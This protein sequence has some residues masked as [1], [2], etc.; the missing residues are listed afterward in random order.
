[1][2]EVFTED[3]P[4]GTVLIAKD[5]KILYRKAFGKANLELGVDMTPEHVFR[6]GS[7]TKQFT[8]SAILKLRDEGK[9]E[10]D[11]DITKYLEDYP[12]HGHDITIK[13]LLTHTSRIK[14]YTGMEEWTAETRKKDFTPQELIE[15]FKYQPMDFKPGEEYRYNNSAYFILGYII[16]VVSG[17]SYEAYIDESFFKPIGMNDSYYGSTSRIIKNRAYGYNKKDDEYIN[18]DFLSMT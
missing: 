1:M 4:G 7:I 9:L 10:L 13:H 16:E 2:A 5:G 8:A 15:Y 18:A 14:S 6:I 11:D 3:G 12:T 17:M